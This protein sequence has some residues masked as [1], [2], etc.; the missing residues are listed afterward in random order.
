[1]QPNNSLERTGDSLQAHEMI[2]IRVVGL[3]HEG[4]IPGRS[5]RSR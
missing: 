3:P 5:A 1:M 2:A 4:V